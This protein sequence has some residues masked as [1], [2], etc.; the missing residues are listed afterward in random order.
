MPGS[1]MHP[2]E[3]GLCWMI[4]QVAFAQMNHN[5]SLEFCTRFRLCMY[6]SYGSSI[7]SHPFPG[8]TWIGSTICHVRAG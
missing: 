3:S 2:V 8:S 4:R 5:I 7:S 6:S 1:V